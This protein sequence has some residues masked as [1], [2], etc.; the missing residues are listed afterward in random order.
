M[1][2][3]LLNFC[4]TLD[5]GRFSVVSGLSRD[6]LVRR[7]VIMA[8]ACQSHVLYE[9]VELAYLLEFQ[10]YFATEMTARVPNFPESF[11]P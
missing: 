11:S 5:H 4:A 2:Q 8:L 6:D 3:F 9:F 1:R 7:A 10:S